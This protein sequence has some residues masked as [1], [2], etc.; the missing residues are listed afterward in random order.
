MQDSSQQSSENATSRPEWVKL[1]LW[2]L[3]NRAS[4]W[5]FCWF[6]LVLGLGGLVYGLFDRRYLIGVVFWFAALWYWLSI[7]WADQHDDWK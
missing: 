7:R 4:A 6:C 5:L 2:G 1:G 3:P